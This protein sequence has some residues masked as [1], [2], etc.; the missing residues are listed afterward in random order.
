[1]ATGRLTMGSS[2]VCLTAVSKH[3]GDV[4]AVNNVSL[5]VEK[6]EFVSLLG[7]SGCGKSTLL[8]IVAGFEPPD[9]GSILLDGAD[10]T[11]VPPHRRPVNLVFRATRSFPISTCTRTWRSASG[12]SE[13][14][15]ARSA[16]SWSSSSIS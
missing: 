13:C 16:N 3:F 15:G 6:G 5:T 8:R 4:L 2:V 9:A 1:M 12:G 11:H 14:P 7:P 10:V